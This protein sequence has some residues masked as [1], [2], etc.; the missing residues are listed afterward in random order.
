MSPDQWP[1]S[2]SFAPSAEGRWFDPHSV[3]AEKLTTVDS[4]VYI[5]HLRTR[6][7]LVGLATQYN[8]TGWDITFVCDL[9][10]Q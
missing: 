3:Q 6:T 10:L 7:G 9:V 4:L 1:S 5:H 2:R 8:V